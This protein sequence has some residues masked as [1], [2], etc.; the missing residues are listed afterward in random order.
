MKMCR[1]SGWSLTLV[2]HLVV[3]GGGHRLGQD[4]EHVQAGDLPGLAG[5]LALEQPE[6]GRHGDHHV[7]D[8]LAGLLL[9]G[10]GQFPQDQR[11]DRLGGV[12]LPVERVVDVL[13]HLP[14][15]QLDDQVRSKHGGIFGL[16]AHHDVVRRL[17]VDHRGRR[18]LSYRAL[19]DDRAPR[20]VHVGDAGV[21]GAKVNSVGSHVTSLCRSTG[22]PAPGRAA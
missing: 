11:G 2:Q 1:T 15:D 3:Q 4:V 17:E 5:G 14:L 18:V 10:V 7:P 16:P 22:E 9:R 12:V 20:C 13:A 21:R 19:Q 6:V 8:L